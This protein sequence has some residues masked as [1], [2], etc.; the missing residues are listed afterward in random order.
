M[1]D[2]ILINYINAGHYRAMFCFLHSRFTVRACL[3]LAPVANQ[4]LMN[5][6]ILADGRH[7]SLI[8]TTNPLQTCSGPKLKYNIE[9]RTVKEV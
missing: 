2:T 6:A 5:P 8:F 3:E 1:Q 7:N 9:N 4:G